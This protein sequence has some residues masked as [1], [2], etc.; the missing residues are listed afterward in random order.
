MFY[1]TGNKIINLKTKPLKMYKIFG[2]VPRESE[3]YSI[4]EL[5]SVSHRKNV[6]HAALGL[7]L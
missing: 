5:Y 7:S 3:L 4:T 6:N 1:F 2:R